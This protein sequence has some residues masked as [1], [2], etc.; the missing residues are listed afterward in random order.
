MTDGVAGLAWFKRLQRG[1]PVQGIG[2]EE[3]PG[4]IRNSTE[5]DENPLGMVDQAALHP[6]S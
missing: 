6:V 2:V 1:F 5:Q 4:M 3:M